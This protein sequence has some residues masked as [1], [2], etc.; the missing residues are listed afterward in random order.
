MNKIFHP[1]SI[2]QCVFI[3]ADGGWRLKAAGEAYKLLNFPLNLP[4][5]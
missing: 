2:N 4:S 1:K 5:S 3:F